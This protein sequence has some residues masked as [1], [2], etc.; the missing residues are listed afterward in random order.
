MPLT[1]GQFSWPP[2]PL[3]FSSFPHAS[4]SPAHTDSTLL[5]HSHPILHPWLWL[6]YDRSWYHSQPR[7]TFTLHIIK[8]FTS[9]KKKVN[10]H[11]Y[12]IGGSLRR[13]GSILVPLKSWCDW[14]IGRSTGLTTGRP[15]SGYACGLKQLASPS[16]RFLICEEKLLYLVVSKLPSMITFYQQEADCL[17]AF[18]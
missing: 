2:I 12:S 13:Q 7:R 10:H 17:V 4:T 8:S 3:T 11:F 1:N 16:S 9:L 15:L 18:I 5:L 6:T 14:Y